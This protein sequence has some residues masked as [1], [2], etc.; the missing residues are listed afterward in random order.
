[1]AASRF[2]AGAVRAAAVLSSGGGVAR[3]APAA[4]SPVSMPPD[5]DFPS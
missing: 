4:R 3:A 1:M 5:P 2:K